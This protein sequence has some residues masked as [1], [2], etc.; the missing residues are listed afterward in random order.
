MKPSTFLVIVGV[1]VFAFVFGQCRGVA[2]ASENREADSLKAV[3][4]DS[5]P[6]W[7]ALAEASAVAVV[8]TT[9]VVRE[10]IVRD[11]AGADSAAQV[12][13]TVATDLRLELTTAHRSR[14][15]SIVASF[16][17]FRPRYWIGGGGRVG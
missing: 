16:E 13:T 17:P 3:L 10:R 14:L 6:R 15:D 8:E 5:V 7:I 11:V 4:N 12:A 1:I 9:T 2:K